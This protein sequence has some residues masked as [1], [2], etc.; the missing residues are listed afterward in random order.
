LEREC[1]KDVTYNRIHIKKNSILNGTLNDVSL[2][3][4][5][6]IVYLNRW[7]AENKHKLNPYAFLPFGS[8]PRNCV[9]VKFAMEEIKIA[10][11]SLIAKVRFF[12]VEETPVSHLI[13]KHGHRASDV[14]IFS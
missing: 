7:A 14:S 2:I 1:N 8:G 5:N 13:L 11:C 9:G 6:V 4:L 10:L 3:R 12:P